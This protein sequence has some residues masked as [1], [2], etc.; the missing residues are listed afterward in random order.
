MT[1]PYSTDKVLHRID[2]LAYRPFIDPFEKEE[3]ANQ[4]QRSTIRSPSSLGTCDIDNDKADLESTM[5]QSIASQQSLH[6]WERKHMGLKKSHSK[7]MRSSR[8]SRAKILTMF[9]KE[10]KMKYKLAKKKMEKQLNRNINWTNVMPL[11]AQQA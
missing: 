4:Q 1:S 2:P 6:D 3:K 8:K 7:T 5:K 11:V 10:Q 9:R